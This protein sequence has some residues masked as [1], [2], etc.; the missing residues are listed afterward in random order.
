[1]KMEL[2]TSNVIRAVGYDNQSRR[3]M[4]QMH[5]E[6]EGALQFENVPVDVAFEFINAE[7]INRHFHAYI[8][9]C[10]PRTR[11]DAEAAAS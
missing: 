3:L 5:D 1:M 7:K 4:V 6:R 2:V 10:F 8:K 11:I 9:H